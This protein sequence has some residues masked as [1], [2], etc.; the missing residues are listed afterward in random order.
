MVFGWAEL[1]LIGV[2]VARYG[3]VRF[4]APSWFKH[5]MYLQIFG[6][7]VTIVGLVVV[8]ATN[9]SHFTVRDLDD[10]FAELR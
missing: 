10:F 4:P 9:T 3:K 5:H 7:V 6:F 8:L 1:S 2:L